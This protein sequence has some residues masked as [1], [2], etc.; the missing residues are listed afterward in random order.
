[1]VTLGHFGASPCGN[2][3]GLMAAFALALAAACPLHGGEL[4]GPSAW[5]VCGGTDAFRGFLRRIAGN[6]R[7]ETFSGPEAMPYESAT[8]A[9]FFLLP[10][11]DG[12]KRILPELPPVTAKLA[13]SAQSRGNRFWVECCLSSGS[14]GN[15]S[16]LCGTETY[17]AKPVY[18]DQEY[19]EWNGDVLQARRSYYLPAGIRG[20]SKRNVIKSEVH[21]SDCIGVHGIHRPGSHRLPVTVVS[22][23][24]A[25]VGALMNLSQYDPR[26]MRP[27]CGW[28]AFYADQFGRFAGVAS[29][30]VAEAF[31]A[32]W[33]DF[34]SPS[35]RDDARAA[36]AKALDWHFRSGIL[37]AP[38][39]TKGMSEAILSDNFGYRRGLRTDCHLLTGALFA[40]AGKKMGRPE[41]VSLGRNLVDFMLAKGVQ[42]DEG[43]F[44]WFAPETGKAGD[45]VY[46]SDMGRSALAMINMYRATGDARYLA[47]ARRAADAFLL[48]M[49]GRGLNSGHFDN[50]SKG[51]WRG[52]RTNDNPVFYG[53]MVSFL[54]QMGEQKYTDAALN[55][56]DKVSERFPAV[57]PFHFSDNFTYSRYLVMLACAQ[58]STG[59]DYSQRIN[60]MLDF[61]CR[62]THPAGGIVEL[63]IRLDDD[64]EA[65]VG[66]GDGTDHIADILYCNNFV[67]NAASVLV[68]LPEAKRKGV[69]MAK[70]M[71]LYSDVRRFLLNAQIE[72]GDPRF[73]GA[74]MRAFDMDIGEY[75]G[76][77]KDKGWGAYCIETGWVMGFI[78]V[79][80]LYEGAT[81]SFFVK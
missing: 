65:G 29:N 62:N 69:D 19:V 43:F 45:T 58:Y 76:L 7:F 30:V 48:W 36:L 59:R 77:N 23:R 80:L 70:A 31:S 74:W 57:A 21:V 42:S 9:V 1:M 46:S 15:D 24:G 27:Y 63:P 4:S 73:D 44:T 55:T 6:A 61:F 39:G 81:D 32:T 72:S 35:G 3:K 28:R 14:M 71:R 8:N 16:N 37:N 38:D 41:W 60:Q 22:R 11:Y 34:I 10:D 47:S 64:D 67:F 49:D 5:Y 17:G 56:V 40:A 66:I 75:Y 78:P 52:T 54:L 79:V 2:R 53:E 51:G 12:G 25:V 68:R 20:N 50:L 26:F 33:P 18:L 13:K